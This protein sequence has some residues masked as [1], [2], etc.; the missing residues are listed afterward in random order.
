MVTVG[1]RVAQSL[2]GW[3]RPLILKEPEASAVLFLE[4]VVF[5]IAGLRG[6]LDLLLL[7]P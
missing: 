2:I 1:L 3:Y 6:D 7:I 4:H 5:E